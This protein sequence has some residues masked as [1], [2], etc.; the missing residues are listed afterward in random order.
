MEKDKEIK[1]DGNS[2]TTEFRQYDPRLGRWLS[3]D[4]LMAQF[5]WMSPYVAFDNNPVYYTDPYGLESGTGEDNSIEG[6]P[7]DVPDLMMNDGKK[8]GTA[9]TFYEDPTSVNMEDRK[10]MDGQTITL[11]EGVEVDYSADGKKLLS[12]KYSYTDGDG[13]ESERH[14]IGHYDEGMKMMLYTHRPWPNDKEYTHYTS[15]HFFENETDAYKYM[16]ENTFNHNGTINTEQVAY[17]TEK[18]VYVSSNVFAGQGESPNMIKTETKDDIMYINGVRVLAQIHT[19]PPLKS[20]GQGGLSGGDRSNAKSLHGT[21]QIA[22]EFNDNVDVGYIDESGNFKY[23]VTDK[24]GNL[25]RDNLINGTFK[26]I[27]FLQ[28]IPKQ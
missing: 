14:F 19:H 4:P 13:F 1:G 18:G 27:P 8:K 26:M 10:A 7:V 22:M 2:Y 21:Y 23:V 5:P 15:N 12:F 24:P 20:V 25:T 6:D 28:T 11:P 17:I 16:W 3:L 9:G